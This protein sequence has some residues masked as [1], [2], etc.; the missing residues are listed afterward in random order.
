VAVAKL[1]LLVVSACSAPPKPKPTPPT[2]TPQKPPVGREAAP[3]ACGIATLERHAIAC[4]V[5]NV[6]PSGP[7]LDPQPMPHL[8][9]DAERRQAA[10]R[11]AQHRVTICGVYMEGAPGSQA[12]VCR[13][14]KNQITGGVRLV[15]PD[16]SVVVEGACMA[17]VP[18]GAWIWWRAGQVEAVSGYD[19][20]QARGVL[21]YR[22]NGIYRTELLLDSGGR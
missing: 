13:D 11:C 7:S 2:P 10:A 14:S 1:L 15:A 19:A 17:D 20:G 9:T 6:G 12:L 16:G 4:E 5:V 21:L 8:P 22:P 3:L 18:T